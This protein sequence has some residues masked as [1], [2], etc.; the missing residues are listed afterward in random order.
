MRH[1]YNNKL[2]FFIGDV[3]D[4]SSIAIAFLYKLKIYDF[5]LK[6]YKKYKLKIESVK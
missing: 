5:I 2:I 4:Y 1:K 3:R 6:Y